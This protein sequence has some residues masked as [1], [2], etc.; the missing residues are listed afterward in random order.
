MMSADLSRV[1]AAAGNPEA[2][3]SSPTTTIPGPSS[4]ELPGFASDVSTASFDGELD[5]ENLCFGE[6]LLLEAPVHKRSRWL[7]AR[8]ARWLVLTTQ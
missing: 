3:P 7:H 6:T 4:G 1:V 8:R 2:G 5:G